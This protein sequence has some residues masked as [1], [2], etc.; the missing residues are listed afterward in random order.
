MAKACPTPRPFSAV[1]GTVIFLTLLFFLSFISRFIFS[2]LIPAIGEDI[3]ISSAQAGTLFFMGA[4]GALIGSWSAGLFSARITH[5]GVMFIAAFG[6][7]AGLIAA[8]F[9]GTI[10]YLGAVLIVL[11][12]FAGLQT[13]S[14]VATITAMVKP[15]DWGKALS[16]QQ[17]GPPLSLVASGL[18]AA[19]LLAFFSWQTSL[20]WVAG[21]CVVVGL[22]FMAFRGVGYFPGDAPSPSMVG[23]VVRLRS[24]WVM[25]FL[26]ALAM[27]AQVGVFSML[28][29][30]LTEEQGMSTGAANTFL[31]LA[32][33]PPL[34]MVFVSGWLTDRIGAKLGHRPVPLRRRSGRHL[35]RPA[36]R[37]GLLDQHRGGV[38]LRRGSV[39]A[40]LQGPIEHRP[41]HLPKHSHS[42]VYAPGLHH[43]GWIAS[44]RGRPDGGIVLA[45]AGAG[46]SW[47][48]DR[49]RVGGRFPAQVRGEA[50]RGMLRQIDA[51]RA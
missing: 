48:G 13:P 14:S 27:G 12:F 15:D 38:G 19:A 6:A 47:G 20:L 37:R 36:L 4:I 18:L 46:D 30:Y 10:W 39:P 9:A 40:G 35:H 34:A 21:L 8:Y 24:F 5:R 44:D 22:L 28:P 1:A 23:P 49:R 16:V 43:R 11:G 25:I 51:A 41:T 31:G 26:F 7:A 17:L 42:A 50:G 45:R 32:N 2:P 29:L 3:P 33:I